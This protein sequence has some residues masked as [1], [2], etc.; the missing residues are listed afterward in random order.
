MIWLL[1]LVLALSHTGVAR[2]DV[3]YVEEITT[4]G[5]SKGKG[6]GQKTTKHVYIKDVRQKVYSQIE[7]SE[8]LAREL[9]KQGRS[10]N[11]STILRLDKNQVYEIDH[12]KQTFVQDRLPAFKA[13]AKKVAKDPNA[14]KIEFRVK[15]MPDTTRIEGLLCRHVAAEMLARYYQPGTRKLRVENRYLYQAWIA[16][17]FSGYREIRA[18]QDQQ[19]KKT[20]YPPLTSGLQQLRDT[21]EEYD[22]LAA[23]IEALEGFPMQ[24]VLKVYTQPAGKKKRQIFQLVRTVKSISHASLPDTVFQV[25]KDLK[26]V[27]K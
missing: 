4:K 27:R 26:K 8:K 24:S 2:A 19:E 9:R 23:K 3:Y 16:K 6:G 18:F 7:T 12:V 10:L 11:S 21:G 14:P 17:G 1:I 13:A 15:E 5:M 25:S 22:Q 20:S